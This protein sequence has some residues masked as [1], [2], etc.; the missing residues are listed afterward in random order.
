[1]KENEEENRRMERKGGKLREQST[2][3][4][5]RNMNLEEKY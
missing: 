1:M 3:E 5:G 2:H 4:K